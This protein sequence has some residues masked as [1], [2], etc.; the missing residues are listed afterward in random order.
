MS[1]ESYASGGISHHL[2]SGGK[3]YKDLVQC[4]GSNIA[5]KNFAVEAEIK[6]HGQG[7]LK[8]PSQVFGHIFVAL[9]SLLL[10][11]Y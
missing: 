4:Q 6:L 7:G 10:V 8:R 1:C 3:L 5:G 2:H 11:F 9:R